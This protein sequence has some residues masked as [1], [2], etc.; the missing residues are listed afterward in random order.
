MLVVNNVSKFLHIYAKDIKGMGEARLKIY[1]Q[2]ANSPSAASSK[3]VKN[4]HR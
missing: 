2:I 4:N 3:N 1:F